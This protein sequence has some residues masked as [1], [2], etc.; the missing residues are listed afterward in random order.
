MAQA[1]ICRSLGASNSPKSVKY[2]L[3]VILTSRAYTMP[4]SYS[5]FTLKATFRLFFRAFNFS[6]MRSHISTAITM[7]NGGG[8]NHGQL[9]QDSINDNMGYDS[10]H[11]QV[12][13]L[14]STFSKIKFSYST[15]TIM[16]RPG[17]SSRWNGWVYVIRAAWRAPHFTA[18]CN[19]ISKTTKAS[20]RGALYREALH[21]RP[22][23][24]RDHLGKKWKLKIGKWHNVFRVIFMHSES[25][26]GDDSCVNF[27][28][29]FQGTNRSSFRHRMCLTA[30]KRAVSDKTGT[31]EE[32]KGIFQLQVPSL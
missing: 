2:F 16:L 1:Q 7:K 18:L 24:H 19:G 28:S 14:P 21:E 17:Y 26:P 32:N 30:C 27:R 31:F 9:Q 12:Q 3:P 5:V 25:R 8:A 4:L 10:K 11:V 6:H 29:T 15:V 13:C 22:R 23:T 20:I